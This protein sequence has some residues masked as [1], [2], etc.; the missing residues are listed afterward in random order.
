MKIN[1]S[2][3]D[4]P[5]TLALAIG[6]NVLLGGCAVHEDTYYRNLEATRQAFGPSK[7]ARTHAS[8]GS[9][10]GI[11]GVAVRIPEGENWYIYA[12]KSDSLEVGT[13][14]DEGRTV[15]FAVERVYPPRNT[16]ASTNDFSHY[17]LEAIKN[18]KTI[19]RYERETLRT[20]IESTM[21]EFCVKFYR[22]W[23]YTDTQFGDQP[24]F[25]LDEY[26]HICRHPQ[27][28]AAF[29]TFTLSERYPAFAA[30]PSDLEY[31][32]D[33]FFKNISF[34]SVE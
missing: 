13:K 17:V 28:H 24:T 30:K 3:R 2:C 26:S 14:I 9:S 29:F 19:G 6:V 23:R 12:Q 5:S 25:Y 33:K 11:N 4:W 10:Q 20:D 16:Y 34:T 15:V 8:P 21:G 27:N 22:V 31:R 1:I 7:I 18:E 32:S